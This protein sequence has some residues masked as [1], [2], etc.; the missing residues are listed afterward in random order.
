MVQITQTSKTAA[1][2]GAVSVL[3]VESMAMNESEFIQKVRSEKSEDKMALA[4]LIGG[5][6]PAAEKC[7]V[8]CINQIVHSVGKSTQGRKR[9][10]VAKELI[11]LIDEKNLHHSTLALRW[12]SLIA[13]GEEVEKIAP[14][15]KNAA[16]FEEAVFCIERI[17][18]GAADTA[19]LNAL[20]TVPDAHK[21]R[22]CV[23]LGHR[24]CKAAGQKLIAL[25][26]SSNLDLAMKAS[27]AFTRLGI[28]A[29]D[30]ATPPSFELLSPQQKRTYV[31][32]LF[33]YCDTLITKKL[34]VDFAR[35]TLYGLLNND[36]YE[37][38]EH[39]LCAAMVCQSKLDE[40]SSVREIGKKL[41]YEKSYIVRKTAENLLIA[42]Q[43]SSVDPALKKALEMYDGEIKQR[44]E[45]IIKA[46]K[47]G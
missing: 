2:I 29:P 26:Q 38:S 15:L 17:P 3:A 41:A 44:I 47:T 34:D 12:L 39:V 22:V 40:E 42:M 25:M 27:E 46:R 45:A 6:D 28:A 9:D 16:L 23:A 5:S 11:Q 37:M 43:G 7:A 10:A 24:Q 19:L 20:D 36:R 8:E 21:E 1:A 4:A 13:D 14:Y 32:G 35:K 30:D 31:D 18:G 33:R